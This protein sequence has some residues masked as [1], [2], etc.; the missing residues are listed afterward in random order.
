MEAVPLTKKSEQIEG[1]AVAGGGLASHVANFLECMST[2]NLPNADV[3]IGA[4]VA[5]MTHLANISCRLGKPVTWDNASNMFGEADANALIT[6][7]YN[8]PWKFPRY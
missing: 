7:Y 5:K 1:Q 2:R 4:R 8:E 6:P 3:E